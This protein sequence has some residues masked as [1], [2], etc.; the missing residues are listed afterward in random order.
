[1]TIIVIRV[2]KDT[3]GCRFASL[4]HAI[5]AEVEPC[6][7]QFLEQSNANII[8][9]SAA[10]KADFALFVSQLRSIDER[11]NAGTSHIFL[12]RLLSFG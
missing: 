5:M 1:M 4:F 10:I 11:H 7:T 12:L 9:A 2:G 3:C 6:L 8:I